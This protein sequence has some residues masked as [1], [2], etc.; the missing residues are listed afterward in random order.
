MKLIERIS[1]KEIQQRVAEMGA[2]I[3]LNY[4]DK[5]L[6]TVCV[7][8]GAFIFYADLLRSMTIDPEMD[9]LRMSS[10]GDGTQSSGKVQFSKDM[11]LSVL[12]KHV[13]IIED[14]VDTGLSI[15]YLS[16]VLKTRGALSIAVC[17]LLDKHERR[18][19]EVR[20]DYPGFV[21]QSGFLV[22]YGLDYAEKYRNL[23]GI[24][25]LIPE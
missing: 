6:I 15:H 10:Y 3:S 19:V 8:K 4:K 1:S 18:Q 11:E 22:G 5:P 7:L 21:L 20:V 12:N 13:L 25:E 16:Q 14:I 17:A 24:F 9:F 23:T 2:E